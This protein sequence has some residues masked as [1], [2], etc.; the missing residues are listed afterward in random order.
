MSVP[1][2]MRGESN[3]QF[4]ETARRL[5]LHAFSVVTK[6]PKRYGPYI[7][8]TRSCTCVLRFMTR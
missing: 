4:I 8:F 2:F 7:F 6:A 5:E 1:K 3:V